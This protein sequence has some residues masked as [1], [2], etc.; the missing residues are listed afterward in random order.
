MT[1]LVSRKFSAIFS[2]GRRMDRDYGL[3]RPRKSQGNKN[4]IEGTG[5]PGLASAGMS[6]PD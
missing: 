6:E 4:V 1:R 3:L 2:Q 5:I